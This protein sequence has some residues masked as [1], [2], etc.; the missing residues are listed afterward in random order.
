V[1]PEYFQLIVIINQLSWSFDSI[2][3]GFSAKKY[4]LTRNSQFTSYTVF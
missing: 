2:K 1:H 4:T 3:C